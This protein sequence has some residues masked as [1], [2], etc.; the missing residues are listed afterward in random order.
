MPLVIESKM[1]RE[2]IANIFTVVIFPPFLPI[3]HNMLQIIQ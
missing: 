3:F 2:Y 1:S